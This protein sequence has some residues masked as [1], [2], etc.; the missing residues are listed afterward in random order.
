[1]QHNAL[2]HASFFE[3]M[4]EFGYFSD[5]E[6]ALPEDF[7][8]V[9]EIARVLEDEDSALFRRLESALTVA[10]RTP[11]KER[12]SREW[13]PN[14]HVPVAEEFDVEFIRHV[15]D[16]RRI[17]PSQHVL[18]E[19]VFMRKLAR[20]ELMRRVS[21]TPVILPFG[22]SSSEYNPNFY[23]QKVYLLL[24]TSASMMSHHR[25]QMAKAA[26][27]VFLKR[28]LK[29]LG[30]I[31]FRT[32]DREIGPLVTA[33]DMPQLRSL[34]RH[35]MRLRRLGNGTAMEKA[36]MTACDDIC[37]QSDLSGAEILI[38]TDGAAHLDRGRILEALGPNITINTVK[39][40]DAKVAID[41]K[42][43]RDEAARGSSPESH[44]LVQIEERIHHLEAEMR[45][46]STSRTDR[47]QGEINSL[48]GQANRMREHIVQTMRGSYGREIEALSR[49]FVNVDD[50][51]ADG[52]FHLSTRQ[53][54]ELRSL[55]IEAEE[56]F[57]EGIDAET[58]K[59]IALLYE[60]VS[61]LLK[62][63]DAETNAALQ[64]MQ[65]RLSNLLDDFM[66]SVGRSLGAAAAGI[67]RDDLRDLSMMLQSR[68]LGNNSL[69]TALLTVLRRLLTI[70]P[71]VRKLKVLKSKG[72]G[73]RGKAQGRGS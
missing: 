43:L 50:I 44:A 2:R 40:G 42:I 33:T 26:A 28:N 64:E 57:R 39:I 53:I 1:M 9:F 10:S 4:E 71:F 16:V 18:P 38:V 24:D 61:M 14:R 63:A 34:I 51:T 29:E 36:I 60:H 8:S 52:I 6:D 11:V 41:E 35:V 65:N 62:E 17:L 27:Y 15:S 45:N 3:H 58:L 7:T 67:G 23:K 59:E 32:F 21:R 22:N 25:F 13:R 68:S 47:I 20:R 73:A 72:Q 5:L 66:Q 46:A 56:A 19:E 69:L 12:K 55:V 54:D 48:R 49:V 30:H 31:Y 37:A 70:R